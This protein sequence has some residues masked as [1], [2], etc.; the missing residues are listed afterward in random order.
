MSKIVVRDKDEL[1]MKLMHYFVTFEK[2]TPIV[3]N[4]V[5]DEIWLE[6]TDAY[7][8]I[9]RINA[10]YIHNIEQF[11]FDIFKT[12]KIVAQV[13]K[14]TLSFK[15]RTLNILLDLNED[16]TIIPEKNINTISIKNVKDIKKSKELNEIFPDIKNNP[17]NDEEGL[18]LL[19]DVTSQ[20]NEVTEKKNKD[21]E[22]V[23]KAKKIVVTY[24]LMGINIAMFILTYL[25]FFISRGTINLDVLF[26]VNA[27]AIKNGQIY[28][29]L[30]GT[31]LHAGP[32]YF[33][34]HLIFNM[35]AL[36]IVGRQ[37]ENFVGK[38][39]FLVIYLA[40]ALMGSLLSTVI[41]QANSIGASGAIFGL[42]GSLV[43]FG[44]HYRVYFGNV[45]LKELIPLIIINLIFGFYLIGIDNFAHIGGLIGGVLSTMA[46][47][48]KHKSEKIEQINGAIVYIILCIFLLFLVYR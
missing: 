2:Y 40:S 22:E 36:Y 8:K 35:Y 41:L 3:V 39:K 10:N 5:K 45:L 21:Y 34:I 20:I 26:S 27:L 33:P 18:D 31:F 23:F 17:L 12:K 42:M 44:F 6:N 47:G 4:G 15:V 46:V 37:L 48:L 1:V 9:I 25:L 24:V 13:R 29:L 30:T 38:F 14:K 16:V 7:Y 43:Y 28:R 19:V 32:L 11:K